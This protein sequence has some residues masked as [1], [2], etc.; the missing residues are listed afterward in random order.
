MS[1]KGVGIAGK[2]GG[3]GAAGL[4]ALASATARVDAQMPVGQAEPG[5]TWSLQGAQVSF[6]IEFLMDS[7]AAAKQVRKTDKGY[8][9]VRADGFGPLHPAL[10]ALLERRPEYGAWVPSSLCRGCRCCPGTV[11]EEDW[12]SRFP[13]ERP[14]R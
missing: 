9:P 11:G 1:D 5:V 7:A 4:L 8:Q 12:R 3:L 10:H 2:I 6:C 13:P 14:D